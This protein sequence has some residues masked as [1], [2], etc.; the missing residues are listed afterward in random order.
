M[1]KKV[2][3]TIKEKGFQSINVAASTS[4]YQLFHQSLCFQLKQLFVEHHVLLTNEGSTE[5]S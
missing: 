2:F 4:S 3:V 1:R 5:Q